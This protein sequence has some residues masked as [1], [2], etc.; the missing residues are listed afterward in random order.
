MVFQ[1]MTI[2]EISLGGAQVET[3]FRLQLDSL[4]DFS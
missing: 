3:A 4:H 1:H 2:R